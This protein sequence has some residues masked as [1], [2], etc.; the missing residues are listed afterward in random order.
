V[1][2]SFLTVFV[3]ASSSITH[4]IPRVS[5]NRSHLRLLLPQANTYSAQ[6]DVTLYVACSVLGPSRHIPFVLSFPFKPSTRH[7]SCQTC[8]PVCCNLISR[9]APR[10]HN[11]ATTYKQQLRVHR[12]IACRQLKRYGSPTMILKSA[13]YMIGGF[14]IVYGPVVLRLRSTTQ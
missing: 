8:S 14:G 3:P 5:L 7:H 12:L 13:W 11:R 2:L 9:S 6:A 10:R 1:S 4:P